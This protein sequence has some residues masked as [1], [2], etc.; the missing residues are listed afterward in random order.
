MKKLISLILITILLFSLCAC[1]SAVTEEPTEVY[2]EIWEKNIINLQMREPDTLDPHLTTRQSVRDALLIVYEPLFNI[3]ELFGLSPVLAQSY[4]FNEN[5]TVMTLRVKEGVL[6]HNGQSFTA[7]D[8]VYTV[9]RIKENPQSSYYANLESVERVEK[10]SNYEIAFF[11]SESNA[12]LVYSLYF[13]IVR[14]NTDASVDMIGTGPFMLKETD[15]KS[16]SLVKNGAWHLG[17]VGCDGVKFL[18]MRTGEM[19]QEAFSSGKI[20]A[21]TKEMLDTENFAIKESHTKHICPDGL[22]EF[23]GFNAKQGIFSDPLLR[24]AASNAIDRKKIAEIY[25]DAIPSGFP[26]MP[27]SSAFTPSFETTDYNLDYAKEVIFS[28]GWRDANYDTKLEK[29]TAEGISNLSFTLLATNTDTLRAQA[30]EEIKKHLTEAGFEVRVEVVDQQV[31]YERIENGEFDAFLGAVYYDDPYNMKDILSSNGR[32]NYSFYSSSE[33][34]FALS[35]FASNASYDK[36]TIAFSKLQ[37]HYIAYQPVA[38]LVFRTTY[39][40]TSPYV[41]GEVSPYPYSPYAN[42]AKWTLTGIESDEAE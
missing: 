38:G 7:D 4:A 18:Y 20:H 41:Q 15:G 24:I 31:Y 42:I 6:W 33:M 28:A 17:E 21:V 34:D 40:L 36:A 1:E 9:N 25:S 3:D 26:I 39:V 29:T 27:S 10:L 13:P 22:F 16:L 35:E 12:L 8:V 23:V 11:L 37:S 19:A 2:E 5:A 14:T 30:A 32:I